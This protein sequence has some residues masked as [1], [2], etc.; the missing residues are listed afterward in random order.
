MTI[1]LDAFGGDKAPLCNL[2]GAVLAHRELGV[3]VILTGDTAVLR[4]LAKKEQLPLD[5][6]ELLEADGVMDMHAEPTALLK[7]YR[8]SS[9]GVAFDVLCDGRADA[10]VSA[11][12]TGAIVVG[13]TMLVKRI[14][15]VKRPAI[16]SLLPAPKRSYMLM[17]MGANA[18]CRPEMLCQFGV[19]ASVYLS[20]VEGRKNPTIGLLNIGTEDTKG[21]EL[22]KKAYELLSQSGLNFVGNV[23]S[24]EMPKGVCDAVI[25]DGFTGNI[26]LKLIEGTAMTLFG[27]IK[28]VL[29]KNPINQLAAGL[30]KKDLY[31]LKQTMDSSEIGGAA[32]LGV[33]K[34]VIKAHGSSDEVAIK[35]AIRQAVNMVK[36][37]AIETM[38]RALADGVNEES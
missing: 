30:L 2:K 10:F 33:R 27:M 17:D 21:G 31:A 15:G 6:I 24:R 16:G 5:G 12:S 14:K 11:G 19:L 13:G 36:S 3:D 29:K 4:E 7:Q 26:A 23:E 35:N 22:Q 32:L 34:A 20:E 38:S 1:V 37:G 8:N 25:T 28:G 9:M 18:E